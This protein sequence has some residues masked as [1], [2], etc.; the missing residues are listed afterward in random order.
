MPQAQDESNN[1]PNMDT[2]TDTT[3]PT[4]HPVMEL[5]IDE[6]PSLPS[7]VALPESHTQ[8]S[9]TVHGF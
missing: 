2:K 9:P 8:D 4:S 3:N 1:N 7:I 6:F 5:T